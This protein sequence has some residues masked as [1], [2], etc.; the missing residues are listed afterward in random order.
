M[1]GVNHARI[2]PSAGSHA[3]GRTLFEMERGNRS[4]NASDGEEGRHPRGESHAASTEKIAGQ[5]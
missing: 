2:D 4:S 3:H 5:R 1:K